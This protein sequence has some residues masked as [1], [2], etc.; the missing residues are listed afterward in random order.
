MTLSEEV[1]AG[2]TRGHCFDVNCCKNEFILDDMDWDRLRRD[3]F[4]SSDR[5]LNSISDADN[6]V[7][8]SSTDYRLCPNRVFGFILRS[9]K[10]GHLLA[11]KG[12]IILLHGAPGVGKTST[13]ECIAEANATPLFPIT[14]GDLGLNPID[15]ETN[16]ETNFQ[17]AESWVCVLLLDEA[18]VFLAQRT[19]NDVKRNA[20]VSIF[21]RALEYYSGVLFLTTNRVGTIGEASRSRIH[22]SLLYPILS[23]A[24]AIKIWGGQLAR[25]KKRDPTLIVKTDEVL[26]YAKSLYEQQMK[27]RKVGWKGRQI[28]NA[29][30]TAVAL[31]EHNSVI[32]STNPE[33]P[34]S[35]S[36]EI[37]W[38]DIIAAASWQFEAYLE[39]A[40]QL[41]AR[42]Y[43]RHFSFRADR[44]TS[45]HLVMPQVFAL[46]PP[47]QPLYDP[48]PME[49]PPPLHPQNSSLFGIAAEVSHQQS[50]STGHDTSPAPQW[51]PRTPNGPPT[52][53]PRAH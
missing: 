19:Q 50:S 44:A 7:V 17:L 35:P 12:L 5:M 25:T 48:R 3:D 36:L 32:S 22:I 18:N 14:C 40:L 28:R 2:T 31:A 8:P 38:F 16:L 45:D 47:V 1:T 42:E 34:Q 20:L 11:R 52:A 21:L 29:M 24:Q 9:R 53:V 27:K 37:R 6:G 41:T 39:D 15:V 30:Q 43:A 4:F 51:T 49:P 13:V 46:A 33:L 10:W 26:S 23:E